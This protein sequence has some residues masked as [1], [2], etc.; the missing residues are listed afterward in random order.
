M[1]WKT[2]TLAGRAGKGGCIS[3]P[4]ARDVEVGVLVQGLVHILDGLDEAQ[5]VFRRGHGARAVVGVG[6]ALE[7]LEVDKNVL[8]FD[9]RR[10]S[11]STITA[12]H[13]RMRGREQARVGGRSRQNQN[14]PRGT[15]G[16]RRPTCCA[17]QSRLPGRWQ[18]PRGQWPRRPQRGG[19]QV[20]R[21]RGC[22]SQSPTAACARR[23][24]DRS[25]C[26]CV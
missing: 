9:S 23:C 14:R 12:E 22:R 10:Q 8:H 16:Q 19:G 4:Y 2:R 3:H 6:N 15:R 5:P 11:L 21:S 7:G 1:T 13:E 17:G 20:S 18:Q 25:L 24:R 26:V